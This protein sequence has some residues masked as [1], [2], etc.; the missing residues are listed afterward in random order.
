MIARISKRHWSENRC[1]DKKKLI[2][3]I[4]DFICCKWD[5]DTEVMMTESDVDPFDFFN[6]RSYVF[7][8]YLPVLR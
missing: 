5:L 6:L 2:V 4:V 8:T 7:A 3:F 1:R